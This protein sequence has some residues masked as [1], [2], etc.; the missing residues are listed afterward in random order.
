MAARRGIVAPMLTEED[1]KE[2][3]L[4][5][6]EYGLAMLA[7]GHESTDANNQEVLARWA[8]YEASTWARV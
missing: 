8:I 1:A 2:L 5:A 7:L 4:A 6:R 3:I